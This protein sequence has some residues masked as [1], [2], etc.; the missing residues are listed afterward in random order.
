VTTAA[1]TN[2]LSIRDS[3]GDTKREFGPIGALGFP[4]C[5][6]IDNRVYLG[7]QFVADGDIETQT[8]GSFNGLVKALGVFDASMADLMN[9]RTYYVYEGDGGG[10]VT[11]YWE[12]MTAVR[13]RYLA[14]AGPAA[15]AVRVN[16]APVPQS[17]IAVDGVGAIGG[18]RKRIMPSQAWDWSIPTPFSQGWRVGDT[19][20]LGGQ[21]SADRTGKAVAVGN[22]KDQAEITLGYI[23]HV[24]ADA[25]HD[26]TDLAALRICYDAGATHEQGRA[27]LDEI[28]GV[29]SVVL[30]KPLPAITAFGVN[31]LYEGLLLEIDGISI[32]RDRTP[33]TAAGAQDWIQFENHPIAVAAGKELFI[34]GVSAPG[35]ASLQAQIEASIDRINVILKS[36]ELGY[37]NLVKLTV[38][39]VTGDDGYS[40]DQH[41]ETIRKALKDYIDGPGPVV[42]VVQ[43]KSLPFPG[44]RVQIDGLAIH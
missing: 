24:L 7:G 20:Y 3:S 37:E 39:Y 21:I 5:V 27:N 28:L 17:L 38:F 10:D 6:S 14:D 4:V 36:A 41:V 1:P 34:G 23:Y 42:T 13:L 16:G 11:N 12:R 26:W 15:T 44:Q 40:P 22:I 35:G 25:G 31:L 43:A 30:P 29:I 8:A 18:V 2:L 33:V 9:L 19:V 32:K